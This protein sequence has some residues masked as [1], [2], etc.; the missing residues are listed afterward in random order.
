MSSLEAQLQEVRARLVAISTEHD[1]L[2][3]VS[4]DLTAGCTAARQNSPTLAARVSELE[5]QVLTPRASP[6]ELAAAIRDCSR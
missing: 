4:H 5:A 2:R 3:A 6:A 1:T